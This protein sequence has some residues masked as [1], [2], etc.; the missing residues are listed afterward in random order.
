MMIGRP[1]HGGSQETHFILCP[2]SRFG[3]GRFHQVTGMLYVLT[4]NAMARSS[5]IL[6]EPQVERGFRNRLADYFKNA[7]CSPDIVDLVERVEVPI[8]TVGWNSLPKEESE[9]GSDGGDPEGE[10]APFVPSI[11]EPMSVLAFDGSDIFDE[12]QSSAARAC[13]ILSRVIRMNFSN[14]SKTTNWKTDYLV[15]KPSVFPEGSD[16]Q[17]DFTNLLEGHEARSE[18]QS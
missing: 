6:P 15:T 7:T 16:P 11:S 14:R 13:D 12:D 8:V 9:E 10:Q 5:T 4:R 2:P 17:R 1:R 3:T 18:P